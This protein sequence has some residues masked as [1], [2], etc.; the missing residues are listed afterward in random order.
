LRD[1]AQVPAFLSAQD[2][3]LAD[4]SDANLFAL[5][6]AHRASLL[7]GRTPAEELAGLKYRALLLLQHQLRT[8]R[9]VALV[10]PGQFGDKQNPFWDIGEFGRFLDL[11]QSIDV[12]NLPP[13]IAAKKVGGPDFA[14][15][16]RDLRLPW[17]WL[18]WMLDPGMQLSGSRRETRR[19]DYFTKFLWIDGPYPMHSAFMT[20][21]RIVE[22]AF[23]PAC[24]NSHY[25]A[26][27]E[28]QYSFFLMSDNALLREPTEPTARAQYRRFVANS[29]RMSLLLL[30]RNIRETREAIRPESQKFQVRLMAKVLAKFDPRPTD[31]SLTAEVLSLLS[32]A[33][34][35][36]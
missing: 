36:R 10:K 4:P 17:F 19:S 13:D 22:V 29:F 15:Q 14:S 27:Y 26:H 33:R 34:N 11:D 31:K 1:S 32:S 12:L 9:L 16:G 35:L 7:V 3:Y 24:W 18:G 20:T 21:K 8:G 23:N 30:R 5:D 6:A 25:P 2:V 28:I